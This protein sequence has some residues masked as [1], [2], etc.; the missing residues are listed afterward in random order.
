MEYHDFHNKILPCPIDLGW[1]HIRNIT[2][3][4]DLNQKK[5][6]GGFSAV[7]YEEKSDKLYL[8]SDFPNTY[9]VKIQSFSDKILSS[10][11]N[12]YIKKENILNLKN[13]SGKQFRKRMDAEGLAIADSSFL[14]LNETKIWNWR[15]PFEIYINPSIIKFDL[16]SGKQ[17]K[18]IDLPNSWKYGTSGIESLTVF[19]NNN[20]IVATEGNNFHNYYSNRFLKVLRRIPYLKS[21][22]IKDKTISYQSARYITIKNQKKLSKTSSFKVDG[23]VRD[24]LVFDQSKKILV[25]TT[26][27]GKVFIN[28][29]NFNVKKNKPLINQKLFKWEIPIKAK[30]EGISKGPKLNS[31]LRT[32][33]LV[34]DNDDG[35]DNLI[36]I[37]KP[38]RN[39]YCNL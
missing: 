32:L 34:N 12:I 36:S 2:I 30:W 13:K 33:L 20:I 14:V 39:N 8:L 9:I 21:L 29:F 16:V 4:S 3:K 27:S 28:G 23:K 37:F 6:L 22:K 15:K 19:G 35:S 18:T 7:F 5:I 24:F 10:K 1:E 26:S 31:K 17:I 11:R 38:L 25:L